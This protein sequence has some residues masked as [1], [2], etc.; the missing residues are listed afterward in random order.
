MPRAIASLRPALVVVLLVMA[1]ACRVSRARLSTTELPSTLLVPRDAFD[2]V[3]TTA[4]DGSVRASYK[5]SEQYPAST[6][7]ASV[8]NVLPAATW[9]PLA[10]DWLNRRL[11]ASHSTGWTQFADATNLTPRFVHQWRGQWLDASGNVTAYQFRYE[12]PARRTSDLSGP[13]E[14]RIVL[15]TALWAPARVALRLMD[16]SYAG[17]T[18]GVPPATR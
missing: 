10:K 9:T 6:L 12:S 18:P 1:G 16:G 5:V 13:P 3:T 14:N 11:D 8:Q 17:Q 7:I 4:A 15:V 2:V